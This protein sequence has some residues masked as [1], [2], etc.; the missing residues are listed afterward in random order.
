MLKFLLFDLDDTLFDFHTGEANALSNAL[1]TFGIEPSRTL[2]DSYHHFNG[3][4]WKKLERREVTREELKLHRFID[5]I[6]ENGLDAD[7]HELSVYYEHQLG[8]Q[9]IPLPGSIELLEE[10]K[11]NYVICAVSNGI[12]EV[13]HSRLAISGLGKYFDHLFISEE[14]GISKPDPRFFEKAFADIPGFRKEDSLLIGDSMTSDIQG[15]NN[16][17]IRT[18]LYAPHSV[19]VSDTIRP[20]HIVKNYN[21]LKALIKELSDVSGA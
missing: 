8:L 15:G 18:V 20:D 4:Y 2:T 13:Q 10:L 16:C 19:P 1:E 21:E 6:G 12:A 7:P 17:G 3:I 9:G 5:F 14:L 11:E